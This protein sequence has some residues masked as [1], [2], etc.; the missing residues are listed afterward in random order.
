M[1]D[2]RPILL[3][4]APSNNNAVTAYIE[5]LAD[6]L[7]RLHP[8]RLWPV[9]EGASVAE[10]IHFIGSGGA[11]AWVTLAYVGDIFKMLPGQEE[12][13]RGVLAAG[14]TTYV[15]AD[16]DHPAINW[17]TLRNLPS[18]S[19]YTCATADFLPFARR[20][21]GPGVV[22][23]CLPHGA[24]AAEP[25]PWSE[26]DIAILYPGNLNATPDSEVLAW[27]RLPAQERRVLMRMAE[28][29]ISRENAPPIGPEEIARQAM[30][31]WHGD[32]VPLDTICYFVVRFSSWVRLKTRHDLTRLVKRAPVSFLGSGWESHVGPGQMA[33]GLVD[34]REV[35]GLMR[36]AR[37]TL[38]VTA[39][40]FKSHERV[41]NGLAGGI[42]VATYG[43]GFLANAGDGD[44]ADEPILYLTPATL[45]EGLAELAG[46][47]ARWR[48][49]VEAGFE[50][51][52]AAHTWAHRA[53]HLLDLIVQAEARPPAAQSAPDTG[54]GS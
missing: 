16:L 17:V 6:E 44:E 47:D 39:N 41:Y 22:T 26:R 25:L 12:F 9:K 4:V 19:V 7:N 40:Y 20:L 38:N 2:E 52:R 30:R 10:A 35:P 11:R 23:G 54:G 37:I 32:D 27:T 43:T 29:Y 34:G 3:G 15:H 13:F 50:R 48:R 36:R 45:D 49:M 42:A 31:P 53:R 14:R 46:D 21:L 33:L 28:I 1:A 5:I 24:L 8:T 18:G 51:F